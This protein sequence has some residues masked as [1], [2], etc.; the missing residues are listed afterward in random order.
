MIRKIA[1]PLLASVYVVEGADALINTNKH[2]EGTEAVLNRVRGLLP[3]TY[4]RQV[5]QDAELVTRVLGGTKVGAGSLLAL[6][7]A[8]RLSATVLALTTVPTL[9]G[10]YAFWETQDEDKKSERRTGFL[11]HLGLLGGVAITAAD[12]E[13]KPG[14]K[15]RAENAAKQTGK[16]VQAA[17]P[18]KSETEKFTD[19][20]S[21]WFSDTAQDAKD[22]AQDAKNYVEDNKDDWADAAR[23]GAQKVGSTISGYAQQAKDFFEDNS[24]DWL[25]AAQSNAK[26]AK[27]KVVKAAG[28]AQDKADEALEKAQDA[29]GRAAKKADKRA[30]KLQKQAD[31]ALGKAQK[32]L[33]NVSL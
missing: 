5:P 16:K 2:V 3:R 20:V 30:N 15:W 1:R 9:L 29:S 25:K 32:K 4:A 26:T 7:K 12:T 14:L 27:K 10:E 23:E 31:K 17:L 22:F 11:A 13:G 33:K 6:G 8:P 19:N 24:E 28:K 21:S 18:T